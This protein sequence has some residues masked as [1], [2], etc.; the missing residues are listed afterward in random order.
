MKKETMNAMIGQLQTEDRAAVT[1]NMPETDW[2]KLNQIELDWDGLKWIE[3]DW[4]GLKL[5]E[6]NWLYFFA[7]FELLAFLLEDQEE[8]RGIHCY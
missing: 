2:K 8:T 1:K 4:T 7:L 3:M 5:I 6:M